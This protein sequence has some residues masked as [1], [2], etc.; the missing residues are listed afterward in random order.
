MNIGRPLILFLFVMGLNLG[1]AEAKGFKGGFDITD[2]LIPSEEIL[3]GGPPRDGIPSIDNP[4]F[5]PATKVEFLDPDDRVLG[6][7]YN[8]TVRAYPIAIMNWHEIVNDRFG[9]QSIAITFCPLC[10]TGIAFKAEHNNRPLSFGVSGLLYN[11]DMLLYDRD[12]ESLW[13]QIRM[14]A[15]SG[16][17][18]GSRLEPI[19]LL[20]TSWSDWRQRHPQSE[21]LSEETGY[22]RDYRRSPYGDYETSRS[23]FFPVAFTAKGYHPKERVL[24]VILA[25][26]SKAYPFSEL[27]K[28]SGKINDRV[29]G[30]AIQILYDGKH[31]SATA[32]DTEGATLPTITAFWFAWYAFHP[33]TQVFQME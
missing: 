19:A 4:K 29:A 21:V 6:L 18:K 12:S 14:Q 30:Q 3:P 9:N 28:T 15:I 32:L 16:K 1:Q 31:E 17:F 26:I 2:A 13:S 22:S 24:G 11:S 7:N 33:D 8:G 27:A 23:I 20:H 25:G 5:I 10:G